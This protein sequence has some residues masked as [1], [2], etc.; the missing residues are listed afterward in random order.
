LQTVCWGIGLHN[1][2]CGGCDDDD[3]DDD[4]DDGGKILINPIKLQNYIPSGA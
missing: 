3:D 2:H 1:S 4:D